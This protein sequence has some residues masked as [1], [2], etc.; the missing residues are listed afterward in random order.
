MDHFVSEVNEAIT[1]RK[2]T[3]QIKDD[4][5]YSANS[6]TPT[7]VSTTR[8]YNFWPALQ[9]LRLQDKIFSRNFGECNSICETFGM[10][11]GHIMSVVKGSN[12]SHL[13]QDHRATNVEYIGKR[14]FFP[15]QVLWSRT[16]RSK[17]GKRSSR[18]ITEAE[19]CQ[20]AESPYR[21]MDLVESWN[22]VWRRATA[23]C[24]V[25]IKSKPE[26]YPSTAV[27]SSAAFDDA[28]SKAIHKDIT[29]PMKGLSNDNHLMP[30]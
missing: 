4:G 5:T 16:E 17:H 10:S 23:N 9:Q 19:Y 26:P 7:C 24:K 8:W 6:D 2:G 29:A 27:I 12:E 14:A 1:G 21:K 13:L 18:S 11:K 25:F 22:F 28:F 20:A 15:R 3:T 30:Q